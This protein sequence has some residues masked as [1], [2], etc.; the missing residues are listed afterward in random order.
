[1]GIP[2]AVKKMANAALPCG[3]TLLEPRTSEIPCSVNI[4]CSDSTL[5]VLYG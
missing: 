2:K 5:I 4:L 1:M 3:G